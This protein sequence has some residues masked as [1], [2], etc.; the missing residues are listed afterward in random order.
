MLAT[1]IQTAKLNKLDPLAWWTDV[2]ERIV[3]GRTER[4]ELQTLLPWN[5]TAANQPP[6]TNLA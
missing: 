6:V 4:N 3:S 1:L 2:L 5:W